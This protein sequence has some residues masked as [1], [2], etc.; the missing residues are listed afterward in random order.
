MNFGANWYP[1]ALSHDLEAGKSA[2]ARLFD[3]EL[4]VWRDTDGTAHAWQ[5][6]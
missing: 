6:R 5:D 1:V 4:C 2:G 3:Q